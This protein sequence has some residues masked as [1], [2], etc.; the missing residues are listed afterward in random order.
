MSDSS[1]PLR[2]TPGY[3]DAI[4]YATGTLTIEVDGGTGAKVRINDPTGQYGRASSGTQFDD[5]FC[6]DPENPT[7]RSATG[8]PMCIPRTNPA[9]ADDP[10]CPAANRPKLA[11]GSFNPAFTMVRATIDT[12][13]DYHVHSITSDAA[14]QRTISLDGSFIA[15]YEIIN[16]IAIYTAPGVDP[17]YT[18]FEVAIIGTGGLNYSAAADAATTAT[19]ATTGEAA[20]RS[21]YEGFT[22]DATRPVQ[23]WGLDFNPTD[24]TFTKRD[25]GSVMPDPGPAGA[26]G[27]VQG[28]WRF[29]PQCTV[30]GPLTVGSPYLGNKGCTPPAGGVYTPPPRE[31]MS[32]VV[33]CTEQTDPNALIS[34]IC[35]NPAIELCVRSYAVAG[36]T[37]VSVGPLPVPLAGVTVHL[38][39]WS[40]LHIHM[41]S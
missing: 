11:D 3:I 14:V 30:A 15:A 41:D 19:A 1:A 36:N 38:G 29:R 37:A 34:C 39:P 18:V 33:G 27:S 26:V 25:F 31:V 28:R 35:R 21:R 2:H 16:N 17:A 12:P 40:S 10:E 22:T 20:V 9:T 8:F 32:E 24:G 23:I 7:I 5:R 6:V 4:D 13:H